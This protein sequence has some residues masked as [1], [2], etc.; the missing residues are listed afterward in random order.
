MNLQAL[1]DDPL[2]L[3]TPLKAG[4]AA[5]ATAAPRGISLAALAEYPLII[6]SRPHAMRM[7]VEN[8]L[9]S[10]DRRIHVAHEI[11]CI[12]AIIDLVRQGHGYAVLPWNAVQTTQWADAV[13]IVPI[14]DPVLTT[15]LSIATSTQRPQS[16]LMRKAVDVI[17]GIVRAEI[18][19]SRPAR[20]GS[21]AAEIT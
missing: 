11:E 16:P 5:R 8:A 7:S 3:I 13:R 19:S 9:A 21:Q 20:A 15:P 18:R 17:R 14:G 1:L 2:F 4:H 6:P 10:V 12:P